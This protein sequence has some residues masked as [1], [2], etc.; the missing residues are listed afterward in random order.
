MRIAAA[1]LLTVAVVAR[2][3]PGIRQNGVVNAASQIP[4]TLDGG[5][6]ARGARLTIYGVR[7][8]GHTRVT[9]S[10]G[11]KASDVRLISAA[12]EQIEAEMPSSAPLGAASVTV[13]VDSGVSAAFPIQIVAANPGLYSRNG[14]GWGPARSE[15][16]V[17]NPARRGQRV[18]LYGTGF[19]DLK[20]FTLM[21]G[22]KPVRLT[23][24]GASGEER[25][26]FNVP[27]DASEGCFVPVYVQAARASNVVTLA[28]GNGA[29][30]PGPVPLL[31]AGTTAV[32]LF[33]RTRMKNRRDNG[34]SMGDEAAVTFALKDAL[35]VLSPLLLLPPVGTCTAYTSSMQDDAA[36][37]ASI[38]A[39]LISQIENR[40]LDAGPQLTAARDGQTR[41]VIRENG[42]LGFYR[43]RLGQAGPAAS[44]RAPALFLDPG[45]VTLTGA[46]G[47]DIG[48]F[49]LSFPAPTPFEWMDR[50]TLTAVERNRGLTV[51]W[52]G[53]PGLVILVA[54]NVDQLTTASGTCL[55]VARGAAGVFSVPR[56]MLA[57]LPFSRD[58]PG[59]SFDRLYLSSLA[60]ESPTPIQ[61]HGLD[62]GVALSLYTIGR[63]I[64]YR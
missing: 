44:R 5:A 41:A 58:L 55:C 60:E 31:D 30:R 6:I 52:S 3:Q 39:A 61:A 34:D 37:P 14:R 38:S 50:D 1:A 15:N 32:S 11:G 8:A 7:L 21:V 13:T 46:G 36:V 53:A 63:S 19:G 23:R 25:F 64:P 51:H 62:R 10:A 54:T 57:N 16:S 18:T 43:A 12:A 20:G 49:T 45:E 4:P 59:A 48:P 2:A 47:K 22:G 42:V 29:C 35:P 40:G 26:E 17:A 27:A 33:S 9:I 28:I 56:A 24:A